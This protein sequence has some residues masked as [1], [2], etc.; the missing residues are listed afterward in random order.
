MVQDEFAARF[1]QD[2]IEMID[3]IGAEQR[4]A[5]LGA[6]DFAVLA[7]QEFC[8]VGAALAGDEALLVKDVPSGSEQIDVRFL[9]QGKVRQIRKHFASSCAK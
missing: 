9:I 3:T 6:V 5:A 8:K 2:P 4:G 1:V 7:Q